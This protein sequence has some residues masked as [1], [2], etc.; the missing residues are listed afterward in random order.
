MIEQ[1]YLSVNQA[2]VY[3]G[4]ST[5]AIRKWIRTGQIPAC[6]RFNGSI[7]FDKQGLDDWSNVRK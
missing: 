3:L 4:V 1:R 7:R 2:A 5:S 6:C